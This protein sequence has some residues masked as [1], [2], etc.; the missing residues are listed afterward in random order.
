MSA[1]ATPWAFDLR[2]R[3]L[4]EAVGDGP[5]TGARAGVERLLDA[6]GAGRAEMLA[7][8]IP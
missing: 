4:G 5:H 6:L 1:R 2:R 3:L 8:P 7:R